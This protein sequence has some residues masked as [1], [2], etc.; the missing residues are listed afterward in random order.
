MKRWHAIHIERNRRQIGRLAPHQRGNGIDGT[1]DVGRRLRL[2]CARKSLEH[3]RARLQLATFGELYAD[4]AAFSPCDAAAA[5]RRF[6]QR[7]VQCRHGII[8][9]SRVG[10]E[11]G[12][13]CCC[14]HALRFA[15]HTI[16]LWACSPPGSRMSVLRSRPTRA[17]LGGL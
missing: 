10:V 3:P 5:D 6:E 15:D 2:P 1:L 13:Y 9:A 14:A 16:R 12:E 7:K 17:C 11:L 8:V 4:Y